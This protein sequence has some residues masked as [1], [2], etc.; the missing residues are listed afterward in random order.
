MNGQVILTKL[1]NCYC[2]DMRCVII[3]FLLKMARPHQGQHCP[4]PPGRGQGRR[5]G[6]G[7]GGQGT[8]GRARG[9]DSAPEDQGQAKATPRGTSRGPDG[10]A[11]E[12]RD[13]AGARQLLQRPGGGRDDPHGQQGARGGEEE[14]A[15]GVREEDRVPDLPGAG[16]ARADGRE[17]LVAAAARGPE[18]EVRGGRGPGG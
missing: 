3:A 6:E 9:Q 10:G 16:H 11:L 13:K 2:S 15:G 4:R 18:E 5:G 7:Q 1:Q 14:G 8:A 12:R 17:V